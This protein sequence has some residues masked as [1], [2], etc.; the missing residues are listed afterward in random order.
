M[1]FTERSFTKEQKPMFCC[2]TVVRPQFSSFHFKIPQHTNAT[3][4]I[5]TDYKSNE[6]Q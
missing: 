4:I 2:R 6:L 3:T 5:T 1:G